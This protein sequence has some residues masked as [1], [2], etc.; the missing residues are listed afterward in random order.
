GMPCLD[1]SLMPQPELTLVN[2]FALEIRQP[3]NLVR[4]GAHKA[5]PCRAR[6]MPAACLLRHPVRYGPM[7]SEAYVASSSVMP[8]SAQPSMFQHV[9]YTRSGTP[10][11]ANPGCTKLSSF[12][13]HSRQ[14]L[15]LLIAR[16]P[17]AHPAPPVLPA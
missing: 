14:C 10:A 9:T 17:L 6:L 7:S 13:P 2:S 1:I 4:R 5:A 8:P 12:P 15:C 11:A 16:Q 3:G